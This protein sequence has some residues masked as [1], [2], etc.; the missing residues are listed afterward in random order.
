MPAASK[1][2]QLAIQKLLTTSTCTGHY[3]TRGDFSKRHSLPKICITQH[4][5]SSAGRPLSLPLTDTDVARIF[6]H[7]DR[8]GVGLPDKTVVNLDVR[9]TRQLKPDK[10]SISN[11]DGTLEFAIDQVSKGLGTSTDYNV[12]AHLYKLLLYEP[13]CFFDRHRDNERLDGMFGTL[14]IELPSVYQGA[15]LSIWSPLMPSEKMVYGGQGKRSMKYIAF[16]ADCYHPVSTLTSGHRVAARLPPYCATKS[17]K[18]S[19]TTCQILHCSRHSLP[20]TRWCKILLIACT[21]LRTWKRTKTTAIFLLRTLP[22]E[23]KRA[24]SRANLRL[25]CLTITLRRDS[26]V[27]A[28]LP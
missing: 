23:N 11:F 13:G 27:P 15:E 12:T 28:W 1:N 2:S 17:S 26:A 19:P 9:K 18:A 6:Q 7:G 10:L 21:R 3:A 5:G 22:K 24:A 16:Y 4:A 20:T 8:A 25:F 14:I